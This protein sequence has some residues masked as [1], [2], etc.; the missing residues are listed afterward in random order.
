VLIEF[1][2]DPEAGVYP[3]VPPGSRLQDMVHEAY[4]GS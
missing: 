3:L 2:V 4:P 1:V